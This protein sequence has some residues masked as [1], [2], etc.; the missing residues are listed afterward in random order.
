MKFQVGPCINK[1]RNL[2]EVF[3]V[4]FPPTS[5][6]LYTIYCVRACV[7]VCV[8]V[9]VCWAA[10]ASVSRF[11]NAALLRPTLHRACDSIMV[12]DNPYIISSLLQTVHTHAR[13]RARARSHTHTHTRTHARAH[14]HTHTQRYGWTN[15]RSA[16]RGGGGGGGSL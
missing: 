5:L 10:I 13:A 16:G 3:R 15:E 1:R 12:L 6:H 4:Y 14:T 9:C 8:R 2:T 11:F 7:R